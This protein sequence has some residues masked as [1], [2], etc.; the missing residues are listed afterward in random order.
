MTSSH[1][2]SIPHFDDF[3]EARTREAQGTLLD[4]LVTVEDLSAGLP[5][6][7]IG[8]RWTRQHYDGSFHLFE[9]PPNEPALSLVFVQSRDGNTG[10]DDPARLGG[11]EIDKHLIYEGLSRVAAD[12]VLAGAATARGAQVLFSVWHPEIVRLRLALSL[13]RHPAQIVVSNTGR[14]DL[15]GTLLFNVPDVRVFVLAG[16]VCQST[17]AEGLSRR[18]WI[19]IVPLDEDGLGAA[20]ARLRGEHGIR[21][22]SVVGG[23]TVASSLI[24]AGLAQDLCLTTAAGP[25]GDPGTPFYVGR[26]SPNLRAIVRKRSGGKAPILFEHL[27]FL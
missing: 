14:L 1:T 2:P 23:R 24:D 12:A 16:R 3:V 5:L 10:A 20:L 7:T 21:R 25:G 11:G 9:P 17:C 27:A 26:R 19:T 15:D 6:T 8:N 22:I 4:P 18:P 13:P